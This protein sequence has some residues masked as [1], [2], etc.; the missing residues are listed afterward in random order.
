MNK[1]TLMGVLGLDPEQKVFDSGSSVTNFTIATSRSV[2][3]GDTYEKET[4]WHNLKAW[5]RLGDVVKKF[6]SKGSK[7]LVE[8]RIEY[9]KYTDSNGVEKY[10]TE[11]VVSEIYFVG[12][13]KQNNDQPSQV[14]ISQ[15]ED[16]NDLPI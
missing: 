9:R 12:G 14:D 5:G 7:I 1:V 13:N 15:E 10:T 16:Y 8:G 2:K 4:T 11:I 6:F 3:N